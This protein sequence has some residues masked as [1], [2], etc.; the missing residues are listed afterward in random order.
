[1]NQ[2]D[3]IKAARTIFLRYLRQ[4]LLPPITWYPSCVFITNNLIMK[5]L[6]SV[7]AILLIT[8]SCEY[9]VEPVVPYDPR[10]QFTGSY[11]VHEY[12]ST[13]DEYWDYNVSIYKGAGGQIVI[14]NLYN[15][16]LRVY[17][18]VNNNRFYVNWQ[19]ADGYELSGDGFVDGTKV[20]INY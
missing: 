17:A 3:P 1:M 12:S 7:F 6:L 10:D 13:Y 9:Y 8:T 16:N 5:T 2:R 18:N 4:R 11:S 20:T 19:T 15:S 14:D